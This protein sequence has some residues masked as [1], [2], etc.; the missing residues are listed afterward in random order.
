MIG[1]NKNQQKFVNSKYVK[2]IVNI[3]LRIYH[4]VVIWKKLM[5][6]L[7]VLDQEPLLETFYEKMIK[8]L[9]FLMTFYI[10]QKNYVKLFLKWFINKN[11]V[12]EHH[13]I[14]VK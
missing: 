14:S 8:Q 12:N 2:K 7:R 4:V 6:T 9:I 3:F 5:D 11:S 1:L 10:F 13:K